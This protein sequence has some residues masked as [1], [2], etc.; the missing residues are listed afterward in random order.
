MCARCG[1][2]LAR[3]TRFCGS[4]GAVTEEHRTAVRDRRTDDARTSRRHT[5]AVVV[6]FV[7]TLA[8]LLVSSLLLGEE[9]APEAHVVGA[10]LAQLVMGAIALLILGDGAGRE[11]LGGAPSGVAL[12]AAIPIGALAFGVAY[13]WVELLPSDLV[14]P[15]EPAGAAFIVAVVLGAPLVEEWLDRGVLWHALGPL[16]SERG[17]IVVSAV[18]FGLAHGLNGGFLLEFPH[19]FL[20][21]LVLGLLRSRS[22]SLLPPLVAHVTWNALAT[23]LG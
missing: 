16:T 6:L 14:L 5:L 7:G 1:E 21:G 12:L 11:A 22:G 15:D 3:A 10:A 9:A 8:G 13:G 23:A 2:T 18:L 17:R 4:C 20:G 19:R